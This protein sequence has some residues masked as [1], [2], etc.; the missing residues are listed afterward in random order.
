MSDLPK[1]TLEQWALLALVLDQGG[2]AQAAAA[3]H[4]SQSTLSY[5]L[6]RLQEQLGLRLLEIQGRRAVLTPA[7]AALLERA[8]H[9]LREM[10]ALEQLANSLGQGWEPELR[11][12][13]DAAFPGDLL[14]RILAELKAACGETRLSLTDAVL[15][16]AEENIT[17]GTADLVVTTRVPGGALGDFLLEVEFVAVARHDHPLLREGR[18]LTVEDLMPHTQAVIRDS[19]TAQPRDEGWLGSVHRWTVSSL[20]A[21]VAAVAA[22]LAFAWLP[23]HAIAPRLAS[24][25]LRPLPLVAGQRRRQA[26]YVVL[27]N[28]ASA[29]PAARLALELFQRHAGSSQ[30]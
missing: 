4:R 18:A 8:R 16:G 1:T 25:E 2:F 26:L 24:G 12:V 3:A 7:G 13:V 23:A 9:L 14:L 21:S 11:L 30:R 10:A 27:V 15:S 20:E 28:S 6:R 5:S 17:A 29:G 22:G 19:G